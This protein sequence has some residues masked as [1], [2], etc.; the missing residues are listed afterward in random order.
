[1]YMLAP[2]RNIC[3][4][5]FCYSG[6]DQPPLNNARMRML[7]CLMCLCPP[8]SRY[9]KKIMDCG[10]FIVQQQKRKV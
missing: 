4:V 6:G 9:G 10:D 2:T 7:M 5:S 8:I 1:M 3:H